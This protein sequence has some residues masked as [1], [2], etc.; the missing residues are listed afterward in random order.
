NLL[1]CYRR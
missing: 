1:R